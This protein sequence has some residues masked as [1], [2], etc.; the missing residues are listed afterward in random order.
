MA[1]MLR[2]LFFFFFCLLLISGCGGKTVTVKGTVTYKNN[3]ITRGQ[4]IFMGKDGI[5]LSA[6][7]DED[8]TYQAKGV[9]C[10]DYLVALQQLPKDYR[11][12][13][14][15]RQEWKAKG[16]EPPPGT[17]FVTDARPDFPAKY[18]NHANSGLT[19][20]ISRTQT[21]YDIVLTD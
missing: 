2:D 10:G 13:S 21:A 3:P 17:S 18:L 6:K 12:P 14:D 7:I 11:S 8:G 5:P 4:V 19:V 16:M 1:P 9:P 15:L 20:T